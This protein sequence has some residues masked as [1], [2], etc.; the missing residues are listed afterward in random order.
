MLFDFLRLAEIFLSSQERT[1]GVVLILP[2]SPEKKVI[3]VFKF[4]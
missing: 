4:P 1:N 2:R 3:V